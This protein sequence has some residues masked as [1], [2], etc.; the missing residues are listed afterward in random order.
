[1]VQ[2]EAQKVTEAIDKAQV[3]A[4]SG[5]KNIKEALDKS[6]EIAVVVNTISAMLAELDALAEEGM[7][8]IE[9]IDKSITEAASTAEENAAS[10]EETSAAIEEQT[11]AMQQVSASVRN[12]SNLAQKTVDNMKENFNI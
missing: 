2:K 3:Q 7:E 10:S 12:A 11:A 6:N 8:K 9:N 1:G 4:E 5:S